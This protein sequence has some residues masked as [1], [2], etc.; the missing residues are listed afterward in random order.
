M[1]ASDYDY[2]RWHD[3]SF[4]RRAIAFG[5]ALGLELLIALLVL[6]WSAQR[7]APPVAKPSELRVFVPS[8]LPDPAKKA[9]AKGEKSPV[10]HAA[11]ATA[12]KITK[13][14]PEITPPVPPVPVPPKLITLSQD[15]F[16]ATDIS[17]LPTHGSDSGD[18]KPG[19][20]NNGG[21]AYGPGEGPGGQRLYNAEWYREPTDA[22][23]NG[24][25]GKIENPEW[26]DIACQTIANYHVDNCRSLGESPVGSGIARAMRLAA[27]Q[28]LV[29]PPRVGGKPMVGA[30][31]KIHIY[32]THRK[33]E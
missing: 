30:W 8:E 4:R 9:A 14:K 26:A 17:K 19:G 20:G 18:D 1:A 23:L 5:L 32:F 31:V 11:K 27:W 24:Y 15:D 33:A 28:F 7:P 16:A 13:P 21:A 12:P 6:L 25:M 10:Q 2:W 3:P 22:E 29:R